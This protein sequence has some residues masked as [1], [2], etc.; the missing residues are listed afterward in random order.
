MSEETY[1]K[2]ANYLQE[3]LSKSTGFIKREVFYNA[4]SGVWVEIAEWESAE[5]AKQCESK[6]MQEPFMAEA[7]GLLDESTL[8][9][10]FVKQVI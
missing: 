9:M 6:I 5:A 4:E 8:Q 10:H 1:R 7:M 3:A 2:H